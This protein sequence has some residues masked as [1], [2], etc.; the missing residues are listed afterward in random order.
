MHCDRMRP[1]FADLSGT[2]WKKDESAKI[3]SGNRDH[4]EDTVV[5]TELTS[6]HIHEEDS[7][8]L[9]GHEVGQQPI[10]AAAE[11]HCPR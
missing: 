1:Y 4:V 8:S 6:I 5:N 11:V 3:H 9:A 7:A 2:A 10:T